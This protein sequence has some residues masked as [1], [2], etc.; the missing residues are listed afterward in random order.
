MDD[1]DDFRCHVHQRVDGL[2]PSVGAEAHFWVSCVKPTMAVSLNETL[3]FWRLRRLD[4][5]DR[6]LGC[7]VLA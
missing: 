2:G 7:S 5:P 1:H 6:N 4:R 3:C